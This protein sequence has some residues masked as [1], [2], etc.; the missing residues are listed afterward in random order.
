MNIA[1]RVTGFGAVLFGGTIFGFFYA[2]V[3][4]TMWGLDQLDPRIAIAA[5]DAMNKSVS[6]GVFAPAF[7]GTPFVMGL[8]GALAWGTDARRAALLF[9][10]GAVIYLAFGMIMTMQ[11]NVAMNLELRAAGVPSDI[12]QA[13]AV[14]D[15]YSPRW[16]FYNQARTIA[17]GISFVLAAAGLFSLA[18]ARSK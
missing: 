16:Q 3:C 6:N 12:T 11:V 2:W 5:M 4:S 15:A 8:A 10:A 9:L 14:W 13:A 7:F 1:A 18:T 17:S